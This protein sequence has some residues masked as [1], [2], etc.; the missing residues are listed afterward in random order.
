[1]NARE[2]TRGCVESVLRH[3]TGDMRL[4]LIDDASPDAGIAGDL[5]E[6]AARD[7][8]VVVLTNEKNL[9]FVGTA[10]RG[11][12][13]AESRD[14]L[15]LN[16]DTEVFAGFLDQLRSTAYADEQTGIATP[17]SN[18]ATIYSLPRFGENPIPEGHTAA[19]MATLVN[20]V[21]HRLRP[22]MPT[23]VGF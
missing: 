13:Y 5:R 4:V 16:S 7:P 23:A 11:M 19:S 6:F 12:R 20:V 9:G 18:N 22:E 15:L 1:Y 8:R 14:V 21:S 3:A 2:F 10:N 17:F